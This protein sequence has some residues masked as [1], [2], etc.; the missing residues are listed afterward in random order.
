MIHVHR[1]D[2]STTMV[3]TCEFSGKQRKGEGHRQGIYWVQV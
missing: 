3:M 2:L 1:G